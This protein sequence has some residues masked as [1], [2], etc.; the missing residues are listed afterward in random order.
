MEMLL[1][2]AGG[3]LVVGVAAAYFLIVAK[4]GGKSSYDLG[5]K[6]AKKASVDPAFAAK[7][8][9]LFLPPP[10]PKPSAEP[11]LI[12]GLLQRESR[13]LDFLMENIQPYSDEQVGASVREIHAKAQAT[14]KKH[15]TLEPVLGGEEGGQVTVNAGFDPSAVRLVGNVTGNPPFRGTLQHAGWR[16][17]QIDIPKAGENVDEFVLMP[18]EVEL[19]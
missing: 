13:L 9:Q 17:R 3:G 2:G 10:P 12:L 14:L 8:E 6:T 5:M 4:A 1:G 18:A 11:V 15:V 16:A 7:V 19:A